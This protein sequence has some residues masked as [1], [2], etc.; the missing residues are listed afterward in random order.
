MT[1]SYPVITVAEL[2]ESPAVSPLLGPGAEL[3]EPVVI[4]DLDDAGPGSVQRATD[5]VA[6]LDRVLVGRS[7]RPVTAALHPL[8]EVLD[9]TYV[10]DDSPAHRS[11]VGVADVDAAVDDFA[12]VADR[13]PQATLVAA[14]VVRASESLSIPAG[15]DVESFG[16]STLQ[17][18]DEYRRWLEER[19][20][21]S[22]VSRV[23]EFPDE[24]VLITRDDDTLRITLN[25]P[26]RRNAYSA[27][28]RDAL[29]DALR[30]P[31]LDNS[32]RRVVLDGAGPSFCAG[33]D[34]DEFGRMPDSVTAHF[35]RTRGGAA[36]L[37][38][39]LAD[40]MEVR[41]HGHSVGAGIE[42]PAFAARVV[43]APDTVIRLPEVSM[44]L[45][46]G[47]GGTVSVPRR[48]GRWRALHLFVT[49]VPL[50]AQ[51]ALGW[52]LVDE[53]SPQ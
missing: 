33:G 38:G 10:A 28:I 15:V 36:R 49:G 46:P 30:V 45:I 29:V 8:T 42:I 32:I 5:R 51:K 27:E 50:N 43:A 6:Y 20:A 47:A 17:G 26:T 9:L 22:G 23:R 2:A 48:I 12:G 52:G 14:Q 41:L 3:V 39:R 31:M 35:I 24:P 18:G 53:I 44:G 25:R 19:R 1:T 11:L 7:R 13:L 4:V 16:Y 40:R 34:L 37:M 21:T